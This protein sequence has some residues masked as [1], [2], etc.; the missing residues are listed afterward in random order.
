MDGRGAH[1]AGHPR[2]QRSPPAPAP[3][4]QIGG[5]AALP[6]HHHEPGGAEL[7][8]TA[9]EVVPGFPH[10]VADTV[11][12]GKADGLVDLL[13]GY[14]GSRWLDSRAMLHY[15]VGRHERARRGRLI[16]HLS[17]QS[18]RLLRFRFSFPAGSRI[19]GSEKFGLEP[20]K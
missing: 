9:S 19:R 10:V 14:D 7:P 16:V 15:R 8:V 1:S 2:R 11:L 17:L 4:G 20:R 5:E 12:K 18:A 3:C 6:L 13:V